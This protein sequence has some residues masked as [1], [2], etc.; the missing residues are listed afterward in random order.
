MDLL[1][2]IICVIMGT[3]MVIYAVIGTMD[4]IKT[5]E[6]TYTNNLD[7]VSA[8]SPNKMQN[9]A[10]VY[11]PKAQFVANEKNVNIDQYLQLLVDGNSMQVFGINDGDVALVER[12][13]KIEERE[14]NEKADKKQPIILLKAH[15]NGATMIKFKLRKFIEYAELKEIEE[16]KEWIRKKNVE[17][18][19]DE[20]VCEVIEKKVKEDETKIKEKIELSKITGEKLVMSLTMREWSNATQ[21]R[22]PCY[23]VHLSNDIVGIVRYCI[24]K[25]EIEILEKN[26]TG[27]GN[28]SFPCKTTCN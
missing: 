19:H 12:K 3:V 17:F 28:G 22:F 4:A 14:R 24:P 25:E 15:S 9:E 7:L 11:I 13:E 23:S 2:T 21:K 20:F 16:F 1:L 5:V 10:N 26:L 8:S 27:R 18:G 6:S